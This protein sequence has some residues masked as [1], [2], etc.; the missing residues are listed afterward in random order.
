[1]FLKHNHAIFTFYKALYTCVVNCGDRFYF[2]GI[3]QYIDPSQPGSPGNPGF[4]LSPP[5]GNYAAPFNRGQC[6]DRDDILD[7][8]GSLFGKALAGNCQG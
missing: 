1:M 3:D 2:A 5:P 7:V 4:A 8:A 6:P